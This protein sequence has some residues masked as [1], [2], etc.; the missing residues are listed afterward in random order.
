MA[1]PVQQGPLSAAPAAAK[2]HLAMIAP[3]NIFECLNPTYRD[4]QEEF[5]VF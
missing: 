2:E 1:I 5:G 4:M 3:F